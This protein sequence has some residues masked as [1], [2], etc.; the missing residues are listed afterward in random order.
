MN[1]MLALGGLAALLVLAT[2]VGGW[3]QFLRDDAPPPVSLDTAAASLATPTGTTPGTATTTETATAT[4]PSTAVLTADTGSPEGRWRVAEGSDSF[5]GYRVVEELAN[6]GTKTAVGRTSR[7]TGTL[8]FDGAA[9]TVVEIEADLTAL[10]SDDDR[11][12]NALGRQSLETGA[13]PT[14]RFVL[15]EPIALDAVPAEGETVTATALGRLTLHGVT[16]DVEI[17]LEG[18]FSGGRVLVI[19]STEIV[20]ADYEM[21]PPEAMLVLSVEDHGVMEFQLI[22]E[23]A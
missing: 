12:D 2:A 21:D 18:R 6:V 19:G 10:Q 22:F 5:V 13:F 8:E 17:P 1:R 4:P 9:I 20:F 11:R 7:V 23:R 16:R 15:A 14:A 3:Y